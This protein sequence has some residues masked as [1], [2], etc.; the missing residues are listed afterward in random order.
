MNITATTRNVRMSPKKV[1]EVTRQIA[2]LPVSKAQA[3]LANIPRKSARL[4]AQTL[5][6]AVANAEHISAEWNE[7]EIQN[8]VA[9]IKE[10]IQNKTT[11]KGTLARKYRHLKADLAKYEA[12]LDSDNKLAADTLVIKEAMAGA[13]TPLRRWRTRA[14]GGGSTIIKR[15][16]HIRI[17]LSDDK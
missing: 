15:T 2:G 4:V 14:R 13:A 7:G 6:S 12:Y 17:T 9:E 1:R 3:V 11:E 8:K 16:S 5:K 10:T